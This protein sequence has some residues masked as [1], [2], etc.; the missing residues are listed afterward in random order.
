MATKKV[1]EIS[2][3]DIQKKTPKQ[4]NMYSPQRLITA[5]RHLRKIA[6]DRLYKLKKYFPDSNTYKEY[7][8]S[9]AE[10]PS[11]MTL[12]DIKSAILEV[13]KFLSLPSSTIR[14]QRKYQEELVKKA[15][16]YN[17]VVNKPT[18]TTQTEKK[19]SKPVRPDAKLRGYIDTDNPEIMKMFGDF[20]DLL[21]YSTSYFLVYEMDSLSELWDA[22]QQNPTLNSLKNAPDDLKNAFEK[23]LNDEHTLIL[24][25]PETHNPKR[26]SDDT[27][28]KHRNR[29]RRV[30]YKYKK[31]LR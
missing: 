15:E 29:V 18:I 16:M 14:G 3:E 6:N 23:F 25:D 22:Y 2:L 17:Q 7:R 24:D 27:I 12:S 9:F 31:G 20:M 8:E 21:R 28:K 11:Q 26:Y 19:K 1:K 10:K 5:Y 13:R 4:L 30:R